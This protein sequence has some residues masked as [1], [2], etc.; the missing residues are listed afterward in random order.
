MR[1]PSTGVLQTIALVSC[2]QKQLSWQATI[3]RS[4]ADVDRV[5]EKENLGMKPLFLSSAKQT[6]TLLIFI[7]ACVLPGYSQEIRTAQE[8]QVASVT[9]EQSTE[10]PAN[11][12]PS[13]EVAN[14]E[15]AGSGQTKTN[16]TKTQTYTFPTRRERFNRYARSTG[17]PFSLARAAISAGIDQWRDSPEEWE[18][19][20]SGFGKR[21][22]S[23]FGKNAIQQTVVYGM[24]S[25]LGLDTGFQRSTR[26][27]FVP[28]MKDALIE[29]ITS[30]TRSGKRVISAPRLAGIYSSRIIAYETWYPERYSYKDGLRSGTRTLLVGFG[31]NLIREFV[32]RF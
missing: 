8:A 10:E 23:G 28:R 9:N 20:A 27:G 30:R 12:K 24:D 25:A 15:Q 22:A 13:S 14:S 16:Q 4:S 11:A 18:Q 2:N 3:E 29:N 19:G 7:T 5:R 1:V 17:G 21:Y 26:K 31:M 6:I 32:V